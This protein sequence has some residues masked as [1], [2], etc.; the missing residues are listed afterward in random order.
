MISLPGKGVQQDMRRGFLH[1][2]PVGRIPQA[3]AG[4]RLAGAPEQRPHGLGDVVDEREQAGGLFRVGP[5][6]E[7]RQREAVQKTSLPT[8]SSPAPTD[9]VRSLRQL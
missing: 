4:G 6:D 3:C 1:I 8:V 2:L 7:V 5:D 9:R